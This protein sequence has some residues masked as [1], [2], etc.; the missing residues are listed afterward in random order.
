M[1]PIQ[2][3]ACKGPTEQIKIDSWRCVYLCPSCRKYQEKADLV[4][5]NTLTVNSG[6]PFPVIRHNQVTTQVQG[7]VEPVLEVV[8]YCPKCGSPYYG[9]KSLPSDKSKWPQMSGAGYANVSRTCGC[10]SR[11]DEVVVRHEIPSDAKGFWS[12][13]GRK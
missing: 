12:F 11:Q 4:Q 6:I 7:E 13:L 10:S 1:K 2:C 3:D 8:S 5:D 9:P